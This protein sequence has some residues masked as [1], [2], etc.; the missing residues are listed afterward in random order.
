MA[1]D[2][3]LKIDGIDGESTD[4]KHKGEIELQSFSWGASNP[5]T[6]GSASGGIGGGKVSL[7]SFNFMKKTDKSSPK[8]FLAC[9]SG[10]HIKTAKLTMR[11]AGK[12]QNEFVTY[13]FTEV[14]VE[15]IQWSGSH[16]GDDAPSE[17]VSFAYAKVVTKYSAQ[18]ADGTMDSPVPAG[19]D[20]TKNVKA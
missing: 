19:W 15:S 17:A 3:F 10:E 2:T 1:F 11:K 9:C 6:I 5:V 20:Q 7:S 16:G 12:T 8:L 14:M 4:D 13:E 18:K